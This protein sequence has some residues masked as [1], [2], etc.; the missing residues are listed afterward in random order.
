M[1]DG[2]VL[3]WGGRDDILTKERERVIDILHLQ[4]DG[5][6]PDHIINIVS[7]DLSPS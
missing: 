5:S 2:C 7:H 3:S 4:V 1:K 6:A